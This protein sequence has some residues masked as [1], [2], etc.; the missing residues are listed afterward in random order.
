MKTPGRIFRIRRIPLLSAAGSLAV[1]VSIVFGTANAAPSRAQ[2]QAQS[3]SATLPDF[4]YDVVSIKPRPG[5]PP[6]DYRGGFVFDMPPDGLSIRR[7]TLE[8]L[9]RVAYAEFG[10][11]GFRDDQIIG[12]PDWANK[13]FYAIDAKMDETTADQLSKL[14]TVQQNLARTKMLQAILADRFKLSFHI[15]KREFPVYFLVVA[16]NGPKFKEATPG[17]TYPKNYPGIPALTYQA[18]WVVMAPADPGAEKRMSLGATMDAL[19]S[20]LSA[21]LHTTVVDKT[22]LTGKYDFTLQWS[23][24]DAVPTETEAPPWPPLFTAIQ[25]QLLD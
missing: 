19:A 16:K 20:N 12:A 3:P 22:G 11:P 18:G 5:T 10:N 9:A 17:E 15:E 13:E 1:A 2:S 21:R 6:P 14:S 7:A 24:I 4:K 8:A 25:Q 23:G